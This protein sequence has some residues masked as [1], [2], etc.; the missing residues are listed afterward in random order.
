MVAIVRKIHIYAGLLTFAHFIVY[1]I[2][3]LVATVHGS[4]A[5]PKPVRATAFVDFA[6]PPSST[7]RQVADLVY[8]R[9]R[10][11]LTRPMPDFALRRTPE[12]HLL[13]DFYNVNGIRRVTVLE[14]ESK[15]K[16]EEVH[17]D[18]W[19]FLQDIHAATPNDRGAPPVVRIWAWWNELAMWTLAGFCLSAVWL[20]LAE[21]P[22]YVWAWAAFI[23]G[24]VALTALWVVFR[25]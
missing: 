21:R 10:F 22:R 14:G 12:N 17:N 16:I 3:G 24:S 4:P 8:E 19:M 18:G 13:L 5:R 9:M 25:V 6:V 20:W 15:L 23:S 7:D 1:G 11:P 2:A